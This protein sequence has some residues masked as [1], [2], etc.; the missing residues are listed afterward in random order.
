MGNLLYFIYEAIRGFYKAKLMTFVSILTISAT[1]LLISVVTLGLINIDTLLRSSENQADIAVYLF[2]SYAEDSKNNQRLLDTLKAM[3]QVREAFF[4]S[5]QDAWQRFKSIYGDEILESLED[6]PFPASIDLSLHEEYH[7]AESA[8]ELKNILAQFEG[9]ET[10]QYSREWLDFVQNL[11]DHF[12][13]ISIIMGAIITLALHAM[14]SNTIKLTIYARKELV[15]NMRYV[16]ATDLF[17]KMPFLLEGMLQ[18]F[19]GGIFSILALYVAKLSLSHLPIYWGLDFLPLIILFTGVF[20]G[21]LGS[22]SAV[23]KFLV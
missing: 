16:G 5:K 11:R 6:N 17:I 20:F 9:V 10:V 1:M 14:I 22:L 8:S 15:S 3:P 12:F 19:I 13:L 2:D 4:V 18:G 21:W 23:R 7:S